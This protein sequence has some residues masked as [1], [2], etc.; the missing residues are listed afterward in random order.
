ME[1]ENTSRVRTGLPEFDE[2]LKGGFMRGD[3]VMVA[4]TP[5]SGKTTLGL[6]YL[7]SGATKF[8]ENGIYVTFEEL[9]N[10]IYRDALNFGWDLRKLEE[11]NKLRVIC[12]SPNVLLASSESESI[13]E[14]QIREINAK[15]IVIDS[16]SHLEMFMEKQDHLRKE[17]Y[18]LIMYLKRKGLSSILL[19]EAPQVIGQSLTVTNVGISFLVDSVVLLKPVEINSSMKKALV[20]LKM[21]GSDYDPT[22]RQYSIS[23][24]GMEVEA[25]FENMEN[26]LSGAP[27]KIAE[28][29]TLKFRQW[30]TRQPEKVKAEYF[31]E[32]CERILSLKGVRYCAV[33]DAFGNE[34]AG[35][36]KL[37][38]SNLESSEDRA[39]SAFR[40]SL[41]SGTFGYVPESFGKP[42]ILAIQ[43]DNVRI[44]A[45]P[46]GKGNLLHISTEPNEPLDLIREITAIV[47][48]YHGEIL[49]P[50]QSRP[51]KKKD[52]K[53]QTRAR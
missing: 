13:L 11:E 21:R 16:I 18:R 20:V 37:G 14:D 15:R 19:W 31:D 25:R 3:A 36:Q 45:Y 41:L 40:V 1:L 29:T 53:K 4:G 10:Q 46:L 28:D 12:T 17:T 30:L 47:G 50:V 22:L 32:L 43:C 8:D 38:V 51:D 27:R 2:M 6:Q 23:P 49:R 7:V 35:G 9:P 34:I 24:S 44:I 52:N 42:H 33:R 5:G 26:I 39:N 48:K